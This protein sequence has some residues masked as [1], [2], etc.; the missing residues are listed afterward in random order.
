MRFLLLLENT[1][2]VIFNLV[3]KFSHSAYISHTGICV[4]VHGIFMLQFVSE[5]MLGVWGAPWPSKSNRRR[6]EKEKGVCSH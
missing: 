5:D 2:F 4:H 6:R 1:K 3:T